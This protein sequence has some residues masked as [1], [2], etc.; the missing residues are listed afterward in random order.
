MSAH[1][2]RAEF[3]RLAKRILAPYAHF[4]RN[5]DTGS[6]QHIPVAA[7]WQFWSAA[8][9]QSRA[10]KSKGTS[11][12]SRRPRMTQSKQGAKR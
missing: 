12:R 5:R 3:E 11:R 6:Y 2:G 8:W 10:E 1:N 7:A 4:R 9:W